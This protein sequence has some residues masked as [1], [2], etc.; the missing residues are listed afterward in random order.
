L[1]CLALPC[2]ALPCSAQPCLAFV[3]HNPNIGN[4]PKPNL[5]CLG[6]AAAAL[7]HAP[8]FR[9]VF[10]RWAG[11]C[12]PASKEVFLD[13]MKKVLFG[14]IIGMAW[15]LSVRLLYLRLSLSCLPRLHTTWLP[16]PWLL[17]GQ[18]SIRGLFF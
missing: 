18:G 6:I 15:A 12:A 2:L 13:Q 11:A 1:P 7:Y 14:C 10:G 8:V 3:Q 17:N 5:A 4:K 16:K 9:L